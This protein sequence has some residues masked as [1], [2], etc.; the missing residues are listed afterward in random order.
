MSIRRSLSLPIMLAIVMI[1]LL[2]VLTVGWVLLSVFGALKDERLA[3][4]Y[5]VL[6]SIGSTFIA[7]LLAGRDHLLDPLHQ[8]H[9]SQPAAIELHRQRH[10]RTE[11]AHRLHEAL[12][13]N[14]QPPPGGPAGAGQFLRFHAGRPGSAG[15]LD[16]P[17]AGRRP[18]GIGPHGQRRGRRAAG[19]AVAGLRADGLSP[20]SPAAPD[21]AVGSAS[22]APCGGGRSI[23]TSCFATSSTT[24]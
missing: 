19:P 14:A 5:W 9:Q 7:M 8:V 13:A 16:Q 23:W 15:P 11:I 21:G 6:L 22:S 12:P 20:L 18:A 4:L 10:P 2:V 3:A 17:D 24:R 1:A